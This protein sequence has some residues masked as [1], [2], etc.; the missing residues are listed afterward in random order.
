MDDYG[1]GYSSMTNLRGYPSDKLKIYRSYV[2]ALDH[3]PVADFTII[4]ALAL[5]RSLGQTTVVEGIETEEQR[6]IVGGREPDLMQG[7]LFGRPALDLVPR[8]ERRANL[9]SRQ[10]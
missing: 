10:R 9:S 2:S 3:D 1:S 8:D 5:G 6:A 7:F 4:C